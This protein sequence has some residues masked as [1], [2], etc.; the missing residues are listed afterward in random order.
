M[1][2]KDTADEA[3]STVFVCDF[4]DKSVGLKS[5]M[6]EH[7]NQTNHPS[8]SEYILESKQL[9]SAT[10]SSSQSSYDQ[11]FSEAN[12]KRKIKY[13]KKR[14]SLKNLNSSEQIAVFCP[15]CGFYFSHSILAAGLH[16]KYYHCPSIKDLVY[17]WSTL[18]RTDRIEVEKAHTCFTC[19]ARFKKLTALISHLENTK[20]FPLNKPDEINVFK[21]PF[22]DCDFRSTKYFSFKTHIVNH[23]FFNKTDGNSLKID[24][25]VNVF[26]KP[27]LYFHITEFKETNDCQTDRSSELEAIEDLLELSKNHL[28]ATEMNKKVRERK[29]KIFRYNDMDKS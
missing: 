10:P 24:V 16:F 13:L 12:S 4:C 20:H 29:N 15:T 7:L 11:Y 23:A 14:S 1:P 2:V 27:K 5:N 18:D 22:D 17:T 19:H 9:D 25:K 3:G 21:C 28:D 6:N 26:K 8:A